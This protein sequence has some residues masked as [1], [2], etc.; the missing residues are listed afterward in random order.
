M[1]PL[2][3]NFL[4]WGAGGHGRVVSDVVR[5][6]G[7]RV[8]GFIDLDPTKVGTRVGNVAVIL[9][10]EVFLAQVRDLG[11]P[12]GCDAI[13][14][15][16]GDNAARHF[17]LASL[18]GCCV[19]PLKH[20]SAVVSSSAVIGRATV[21]GANAVVN[22]G[23][24]VGQAVI[25]N[26]AAIVEHD[27]VIGDCAHVSPGAIIAGGASVGERSWIGA[28]ATVIQGVRI[29]ADVTI[30]AGAVVIRDVPDGLTMAGVPAR[31]LGKAS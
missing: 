21:V 14:L 5:A 26:S 22:A 25:I 8:G 13:A 30:G 9:H 27:C 29:G 2:S 23:A 1:I 15:A 6:C 20:P 11:I 4:V 10:E 31:P 16:L 7:Y 12:A 28:G 24:C 17:A 3:G 19:P 18:S